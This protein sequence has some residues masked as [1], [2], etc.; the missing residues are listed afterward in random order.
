MSKRARPFFKTGLA[1]MEAGMEAL[2]KI[3]IPNN[4]THIINCLEAAG[5]EAYAVGGCVRDSILGSPPKDWDITTSAKPHETK[6]LFKKTVDTGLTH[7]TVTVLLDGE[8][9]EVTT[10]RIDGEYEDNRHPKEVLFTSNLIEDLK[11]RDFTINAMAYN[12]RVGMV[13]Q[14][15][16]TGDLEKGIIRCVG[17]AGE[18][19]SEDALRILRAIRFSAQ[20]GFEIGSRTL[21]AI[22]ALAGNLRD[23]SAERIQVEMVK[24]FTSDHPDYLKTAW[25]SGITEVILPEFDLMMETGQNTSHHCYS[26]GE[27][28]LAAL[29]EIEADK[30]LRL[31]VLFHDIGKPQTKSTDETGVDHFYRHAE[32]GEAITKETLRRWKF[33]NDTISKVTKLVRLH[34]M[35]P[36]PVDRSVRKAAHYAGEELFPLLLKLQKADILAQSD[37]QKAEK[38]T[39]LEK[40]GEIYRSILIRQECLTLKDLAIT[41]KDLIADGMKPGKELGDTLERLLVHILEDPSHN[42][43]EYL[44]QYARGMR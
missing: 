16:G 33:D 44:I 28:T 36:A 9:Y 22:R 32:A 20:L 6:S 19:F 26:V 23:I 29:K 12:D 35:R 43:K 14:F 4:V 37:Y 31:A 38:L 2:V 7:G 17:D 24:L 18:R 3:S 30:V 21:D 11:R 27:H 8:G 42:T 10:F 5:Y 40:V 1:G 39:D 13:D 25:E 41:G 34:D 15:D